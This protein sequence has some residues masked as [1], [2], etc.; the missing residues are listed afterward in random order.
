MNK[1]IQFNSEFLSTVSK[2]S[3]G[4]RKKGKPTIS[5]KNNSKE[6]RQKLLER[7]RDYQNKTT[8]QKNE[9]IVSNVESKDELKNDKLD[10]TFNNS[11]EILKGLSSSIASSSI[12]H[13]KTVKHKPTPN[14]ISLEMPDSFKE[15]LLNNTPTPTP[16]PSSLKIM[17]NDEV[18]EELHNYNND[19]SIVNIKEQP[20]YSCL[21]NGTRPT[22]KQLINQSEPEY[23][24]SNN[25][26][27]PNNINSISPSINADTNQQIKLESTTPPLELALNVPSNVPSTVNKLNNI[28]DKRSHQSRKKMITKTYK[29]I[30]GK[31]GRNVSVLLKD[32]KTRKMVKKECSQLAH[33]SMQDIKSYLRKKNLLKIG[34][35]ASD[36]VIKK[37]YEQAILTGEVRNMSKDTL[38]HNF[39]KT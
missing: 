9:A 32:L 2:K 24:V 36:E 39:M 21:K 35:N 23:S 1:T 11:L 29:Y 13:N 16:T 15:E 4:T 31:N 27:S 34:S 3:N 28:K 30:L 5:E 7:I 33:T 19:D 25:S 20:L 18:E 6:L 37:I 14:D 8:S 17:V 10:N 38:I 12:G 26:G 22:Y